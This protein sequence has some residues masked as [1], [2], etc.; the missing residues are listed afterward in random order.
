MDSAGH[1][2][3]SEVPVAI[4]AGGA[5]TL[6]LPRRTEALRRS[7]GNLVYDRTIPFAG[8]NDVYDRP[9]FPLAMREALAACLSRRPRV[10]GQGLG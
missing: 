1:L 6:I 8:H 4:V 9:A 2:A 7:V 10:P 3:K 5:D